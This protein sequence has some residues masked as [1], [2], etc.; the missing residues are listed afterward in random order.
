MGMIPSSLFS[1]VKKFQVPIQIQ[2]D[3]FAFEK[4]VA[5]ASQNV[6][7][8]QGVYTLNT[9]FFKYDVL[10][11]TFF[12][13]GDFSVISPKITCDARCLS[14][15]IPSRN[16]SAMTL[17]AFVSPFSVKGEK[18]DFYSDRIE[19]LNA[20]FTTCSLENPHYMVK[21]Q[22][23]VVYPDKNF[24]V[25]FK[26]KF[27]ISGLAIPIPTY[28]YGEKQ[29]P[30]ANSFIPEIG[31]NQAEGVF[32]KES[33]GYF[34]SPKAQGAVQFGIN[35]KQGGFIALLNQYQ[36]D[37][38]WQVN[39]VFSSRIKY[40]G[41]DKFEG[42]GSFEV[43]SNGK[44]QNRLLEDDIEQFHQWRTELRYQYREI[45]NDLH[46]SYK[47]LFRH[48]A[49]LRLNR[50]RF[51]L[52]PGM[53]FIQEEPLMSNPNVSI[54]DYRADITNFLA[55]EYP[56]RSYILITPTYKHY[57]HWYQKQDWHRS[58]LGLSI[59]WVYPWVSPELSYAKKVSITGDT[60]FLHEKRYALLSD[61]LGFGLKTSYRAL[62]FQLEGF[63]NLEDHSFR[64]LNISTK[65]K[66]HCVTMSLKWLLIQQSIG[67]GIDL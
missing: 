48:E 19:I 51:T 54:S 6:I 1:D 64:T 11:Q 22:K 25:A 43:Q 29:G 21:S 58:F 31:S 67:F 4:D 16:G 9:S 10:S 17:S 42:H 65:I 13:P 3:Y 28:F 55:Y 63:Y 33:I 24:F 18:V 62:S 14:Y 27:M 52:S 12:I 32:I 56:Y 35:Q 49:K 5:V 60:P 20:Y 2:A 30:I 66:V 50:W 37:Q 59:A 41:Q 26:N 38:K 47:P 36:F 23:M 57:S 39:P 15:S 40:S 53:A 8:S 7:L 44:K 46:V 34:L 61:E 45:V